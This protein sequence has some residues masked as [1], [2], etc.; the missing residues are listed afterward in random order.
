MNTSTLATWFAQE[1]A[2]G[3][4]DIKLAVVPGKGISHEKVGQEIIAAEL[5]IDRGFTRDAPSAKSSIPEEI[6]A[7]FK[8]FNIAATQA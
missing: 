5:A 6:M 7:V 3:L 2:K 4:V 1:T 8:T